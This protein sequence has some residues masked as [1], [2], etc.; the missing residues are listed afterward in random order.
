MNRIY[1]NIDAEWKTENVGLIKEKLGQFSSD[2]NK[3]KAVI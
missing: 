2:F 3:T 1:V